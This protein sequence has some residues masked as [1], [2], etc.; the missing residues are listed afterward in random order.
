MTNLSL[1]MSDPFPTPTYQTYLECPCCGDV[2][3]ES[4]LNGHYYDGQPLVCG[5]D[6]CVSVDEDDV[7]INADGCE[8]EWS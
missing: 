2:G 6:G 8:C 4:D 7:Y 3:A 1:R 5:C